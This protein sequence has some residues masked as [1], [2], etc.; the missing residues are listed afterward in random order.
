MDQRGVRFIFSEHHREQR[1]L[2]VRAQD[3]ITFIER[4]AEDGMGIVELLR[5]AGVLCALP[6]E[7][8][9]NPRAAGALLLAVIE[10][11]R[12][13]SLREG[14]QFTAGF[15]QRAHGQCQAV[16]KMRAPGI[17][18]EGDIGSRH[19]PVSEVTGV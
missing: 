16:S 14:G 3:L 8:E 9:G 7:Q 5:H 1:A 19:V 2:Q 10:I 15:L 18:G 4:V 12:L 17:G 13:G 6:G 11:T